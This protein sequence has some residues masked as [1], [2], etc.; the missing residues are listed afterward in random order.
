LYRIPPGTVLLKISERKPIAIILLSN[1]SAIV[2]EEGYILNRTPGLTLNIPN[3]TDLPVIFGVGSQEVLEGERINPKVTPLV[4]HIALKLSG[5]L[6]SRRIRL[7]LGENISFL[8]DDNLRV[9]LGRDENVKRKMEVFEGI[10]SAIAGKWT[11]IDY[12]DVRFPDNPV[13]KYR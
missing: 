8:L 12:V 4:S 10:L 6:G 7:E 11:E 9:K 1:K 5:L 3:M 13:V 2:D